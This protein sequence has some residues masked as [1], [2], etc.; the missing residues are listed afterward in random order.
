MA[1]AEKSPL[2]LHKG[3]GQFCKKVNGKHVYFGKDRTTALKKYRDLL[4]GKAVDKGGSVTLRDAINRYLTAKKSAAESGAITDRYFVA[5]HK[6][7]GRVIRKFGPLAKVKDLTPADFERF[8]VSLSRRVGLYATAN[9]LRH[10]RGLFRY[11]YEAGL[12]DRPLRFGPGLA[13]PAAREFRR[14]RAA[15]GPR[16]LSAAEI[17]AA[18]KLAS[19]QV[20]AAIMLGINAAF[21]SGD[22]SELPQ[23]A[24]DFGSGWLTF[25]RPKTGI[26]RRVPLWSETI[27]AVKLAIENRPIPKDAADDD[28]VFL[29]IRGNRWVRDNVKGVHSDQFGIEFKKLLREAEIDRHGSFYLLRH[30]FA[31]IAAET[32]LQAAVGA[33][34]GHVDSTIAGVYRERLPDEML[35]KAT[36]H[37][38]DWLFAK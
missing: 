28:K 26:G 17:Q 12:I 31:T 29:T 11:C 2:F 32:G 9:E 24:I 30:T 7:C 20:K 8:R 13:V 33:V 4:E 5:I 27:E 6:T 3:T 15:N 34:M 22:C 37:V 23:H 16:L 38:H 25:P 35:R 1:V 36:D 18:M 19:P 10:A 14:H 21:G